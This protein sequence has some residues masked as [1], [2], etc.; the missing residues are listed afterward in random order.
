MAVK[1][2]YGNGKGLAEFPRLILAELGIAFEDVRWPDEDWDTEIA[3][4]KP[5]LPFGQV[6][7]YEEG[8]LTLVQ[9]MAIARHL[10]R[11]GNLYGSS[12]EKQAL[13]DMY[14]DGLTDIRTKRDPLRYFDDVPDSIKDAQVTKFY[15]TTLPQWAGYFENFLAD[16][17]EYLAGEFTVADIYAYRI[18]SDALDGHAE[19][20]A[21]TPK[22]LALV[23]RVAARPNIAAYLAK[24]PVTA[25]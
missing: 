16:G 11:K 7:L 5:T 12:L 2:T 23:A 3:K 17:R 10:A 19:C 21:A 18:F 24:R 8:G 15:A 25:W 14:L 22:V 1:V 13:V 9:S 4:L 6:P 20:F